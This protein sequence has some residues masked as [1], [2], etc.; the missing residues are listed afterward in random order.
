M[1]TAQ[2]LYE[3]GYITYMRTDSVNLSPEAIEAAKTEII[4]T[5]GELYSRPRNYASKSKGAQEAH[6]A[7]RPT[8]MSVHS[9]TLDRDQAR[10]YDLIW[11][12]TLASQM[13][14]AELERTNVKIDASTH[15]EQ[16]V[17]QGEVLIFDGFLKVYL[18]SHDDEEEEQEGMLPAMRVGENLENKNITATERYSRPPARYTEALW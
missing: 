17:A 16:F 4:S 15:K 9:L 5:Y 2:R 1:S 13:S 8:D 7:I 12:R 10:L 3:S 14:D 6:E 11:K 18:E